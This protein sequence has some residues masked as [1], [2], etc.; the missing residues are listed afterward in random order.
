M[1]IKS[2]SRTNLG[3]SGR[4][5]PELSWVTPRAK[6]ITSTSGN[7]KRDH[8]SCFDGTLKTCGN[9]DSSSDESIM[10]TIIISILNKMTRDL[11]VKSGTLLS[12]I[13]R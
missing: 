13:A 11:F 9:R 1:T 6:Q 3:R 4:Y 8:E 5:F 2:A 7:I 10:I 12:N